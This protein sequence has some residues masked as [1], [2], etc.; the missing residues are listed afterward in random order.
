MKLYDFAPA[1]NAQRVCVFL[2]EK[3]LEVPHLQQELH[4]SCVTHFMFAHVETQC[5][6]LMSVNAGAPIAR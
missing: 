5:L 6:H 3:G 1:S 4:N 2:A